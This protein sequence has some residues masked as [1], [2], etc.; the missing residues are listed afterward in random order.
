MAPNLTLSPCEDPKYVF[1]SFHNLGD[2]YTA[3]G[4][5]ENSS[6]T[7]IVEKCLI[8]YCK[9]PYSLL[10]GCENWHGTTH[11]PF[12]ISTTA[13]N[14]FFWNNATCAGVSEGVNIDIGGPGVGHPNSTNGENL[15]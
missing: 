8:D 1:Q 11:L 12:V 5:T 3:I 6:F 2:C 10:G 7:K 15:S 14:Q 9:N 4:G 13:S